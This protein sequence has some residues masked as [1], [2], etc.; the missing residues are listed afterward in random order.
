MRVEK[1]NENLKHERHRQGDLKQERHRQVDLKQERIR[2]DRQR[3]GEGN[4]KHYKH[5]YHGGTLIF[6]DVF[7]LSYS[8]ATFHNLNLSILIKAKGGCSLS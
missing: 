4:S 7:T 5:V 2:H 8:G 3:T 6:D 1:K